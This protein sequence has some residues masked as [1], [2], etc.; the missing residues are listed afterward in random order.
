MEIFKDIKG[1]EGLYQVSNLG[2]VRSYYK[3]KEGKI[4][5]AG[6][7]PEGYKYVNLHSDKNKNF[8]IHR[9][10]A[11]AFIPNPQNKTQVNHINGIKNDNRLDNLEWAT[12]SE[13]RLH[14]YKI[15]LQKG[16]SINQKKGADNPRSRP[17]VK[18]NINGEFIQNYAGVCEA[19]RQIGGH[20][21]NISACCKGKTKTAYSFKWQYKI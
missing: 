5:S 9:L 3:D 4:L 15:G 19:A 7:K 16:Q 10:V 8:Y 13:N 18:L 21:A 11:L 14:A 2:N 12:S 6:L 17:V 20:Q 1:Y